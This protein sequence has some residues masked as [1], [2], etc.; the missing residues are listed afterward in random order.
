MTI[1]QLEFSS[2]DLE[3][4]IRYTTVD[5]PVG[6]LLLAGDGETITHLAMDSHQVALPQ[7]RDEW[8]HDPRAFK[9]AKAQLREYFAGKRN[10]FDLPLAPAGTDF[11]LRVWAALCAIPYGQ[12]AT[13]GEVAAR[14]GNPKASRAV[15]MANHFNPIALVIPCHRVIGSSG[16]LV[17][18]GGGLDRKVQLLTLEGAL[19]QPTLTAP[20]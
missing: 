20:A 4:P 15:G 1:T 9:T 18:Y 7:L 2:A 8:K 12:T 16:S 6:E 11:Q 17:G 3:A 10:V 13:Y 14:A 19:N 5:S